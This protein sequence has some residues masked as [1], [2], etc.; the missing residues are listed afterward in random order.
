MGG[1]GCDLERSILVYEESLMH[2]DYT[3]SKRF[4]C[5][6]NQPTVK[7]NVIC[8]EP[9]ACIFQICDCFTQSQHVLDNPLIAC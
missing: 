6:V 1:S 7:M 8:I 3:L 5:C 4:C 9:T 2:L